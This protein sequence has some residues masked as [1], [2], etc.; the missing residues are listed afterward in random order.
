MINFECEHCGGALT[1]ADDYAGRDGWCRFCRQMIIIPGGDS[2]ERVAD[3][4]P[5]E[6]YRRMGRLLQYAARRA[7]DYKQKTVHH[8]QEAQRLGK[9]LEVLAAGNRPEPQEMAHAEALEAKLEAAEERADAA[10]R[11]IMALREEMAA[12]EAGTG[13]ALDER[14]DRLADLESQREAHEATIARLRSERDAAKAQSENKAAAERVNVLEL[15]LADSKTER[16]GLR[17]ALKDDRTMH[18][19]A[20]AKLEAALKAAQEQRQASAND[21]QTAEA[22]A[23]EL[24]KKLAAA[25]KA[26]KENQ[27]AAD[28]A[29]QTEIDKAKAKLQ[30]E[31]E[32]RIQKLE[33]QREA[34]E[35]VAA[36]DRE[37]T[38]IAQRNL[39]ELKAEF[40]KSESALEA[41]QSAF[42]K[43]EARLEELEN[44]LETVQKSAACLIEQLAAPQAEAENLRQQLAAE[45]AEKAKL[46]TELDAERKVN[47]GLENALRENEKLTE[48]LEEA[49]EANSKLEKALAGLEAS[50]ADLPGQLDQAHRAL[51]AS[52]DEAREAREKRELLEKDLENLKEDQEA[53]IRAL[54]DEN[55]RLEAELEAQNAKEDRSEHEAQL[56]DDLESMT[57]QLAGERQARQA[58]EAARD[59]FQRELSENQAQ[60]ESGGVETP[61]EEVEVLGELTPYV[62]EEDD[63][64]FP[65]QDSA[66]VDPRRKDM[67]AT[68]REFL[69]RE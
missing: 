25:E 46:L 17:E 15:K 63:E 16:D 66:F 22:R 3:L 36:S 18:A 30:K 19:G 10:E 41:L 8:K 54:Y 29:L 67:M 65:A 12:L 53:A 11:Q 7:D 64:S 26:G 21:A 14:N 6:R 68:L 2:T 20:I 42:R 34:A 37:A 55:K 69:D 62:P 61:N 51:Q 1:G 44:D 23:T 58:A 27:R 35:T 50:V 38:V 57:A 45:G 13:K 52:K 28:H 24:E 5:E 32:G 31:Y 40:E 39:R 59:A 47:A 60:T 48:D 33:S 43:K 9:E 49:R 4:S 56:R